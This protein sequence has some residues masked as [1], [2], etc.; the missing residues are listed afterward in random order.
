[1]PRRE[2]ASQSAESAVDFIPP[3]PTLANLRAASKSCKGCHLW[4][5]GTQTVFG[6]GPKRASVMLVGEQPGDAEDRAGHP[7]V[8]PAG[9]LLDRALEEAGIDRDDVYVTNAV[10]HFKWERDAKGKRRIHK[11]PNA[12]EV[13]ACF[14][15]LEQE[16][17]LVQ[18]RVIVALGATAAKALLGRGFSVLED[19]GRAIHSTWADAV[20]ATVHPSAVLRAPREARDE[21]ERAFFADLVRVAKHLRGKSSPSDVA[22]LVERFVEPEIRGTNR[23]STRASR[24]KAERHTESSRR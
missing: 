19:R 15:W 7:F 13:R 22:R 6:E 8:G 16:I 14:P 21:A 11:T 5:L 12:A 23:S 4:K 9:K 18:P 1:M 3:N 24:R 20:I 17:A 2:R 10:K